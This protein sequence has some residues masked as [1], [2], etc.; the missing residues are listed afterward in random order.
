MATISTM[1]MSS[2]HVLP[3]YMTTAQVACYIGRT[4][5]AIFR[6]VEKK[7]IPFV[8]VGG[9]LQF[10]KELIDEWMTGKVIGVA[11]D[12]T[13]V[14]FKGLPI[15]TSPSI[16]PGTLYYMPT[17][18]WGSTVLTTTEVKEKYEKLLEADRRYTKGSVDPSMV[19][20][21]SILDTPKEVWEMVE[22]MSPK[23]EK[24]PH[25]PGLPKP[26]DPE[27][28]IDYSIRQVR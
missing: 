13:S 6:L 12:G 28:D 19:H 5:K 18:K 4:V 3:R 25:H 23:V 14:T 8:K 15:I 9:R 24:S 17:P 27:E 1:P 7:R 2:A 10:D 20:Y 22:G 16:A 21:K 11:T 26:A